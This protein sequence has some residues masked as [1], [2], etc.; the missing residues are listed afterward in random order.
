[1]LRY[2]GES[3]QEPQLTSTEKHDKKKKQVHKRKKK[4][5]EN[6]QVEK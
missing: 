2:S 3:I 5:Y 1:M 6:N 4:Q